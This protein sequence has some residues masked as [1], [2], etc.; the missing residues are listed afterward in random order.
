MQDVADLS[1]E[2]L[3]NIQVTSVSKRPERLQDAPAAVFVIT[4]DDI[5]RSGADSLPEALRLAPNLHV[6]RINGYAYSISA[7]GLN[8]GGSAV[9]NK[10]LVLID[11]RSV[12]TPLFS[13]VFW[14]AQD[15]LL[16]DV[17]RIEVVSGPGGVLWGL[18]AVN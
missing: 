4:A 17:E 18:N 14:D 5:R 3:A 9:S 11:G 12:Y 1:I 8:S 7:R 10:L 15:V 16:E 13:G 2:E 6:A